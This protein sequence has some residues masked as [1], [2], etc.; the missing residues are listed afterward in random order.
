MAIKVT[1]PPTAEPITLEEAKAQCKV[2]IAD[3]DALITSLITAAR[4]YCEKIGWRAY[5]TQ[6]IQLWID[7]WPSSGR[8]SLPKPPLQSVTSIKYYD[9][10]DVEA[11]LGTDVYAVD[12]ISEPGL[13]WLKYNQTWPTTLLREHHGICVTYVAGW[14]YA[15]NVPQSEKQAMLLLVG[16]W[17]EN[18]EATT[19]GVVSRPIDFAVRALLGLDRAFEY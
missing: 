11:T 5:L 13:A 16:H 8:I 2:D 15:A 14:T 19:V 4:V 7:E 1:V 17:Y 12:T 9:T 10:A 6:T 3:D 18:R